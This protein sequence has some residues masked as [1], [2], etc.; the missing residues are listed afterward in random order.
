MRSCD[1]TPISSPSLPPTFK[2][3]MW[4]AWDLTLDLSLG[5]LPGIINDKEPFRQL[6]FFEEQLTA[7]E[8]WL[9]LGKRNNYL[10][11]KIFFII[12]PRCSENT[13]NFRFFKNIYIYSSTLM[14]CLLQSSPHL[15]PCTCTTTSANP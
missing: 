2:H 3:P 6:P 7:F 12:I 10:V 5:Q 1:C 14:L 11:N 15:M 13:R 8:V 4:N 9:N